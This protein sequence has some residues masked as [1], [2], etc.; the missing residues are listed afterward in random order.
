ML[1]SW[2]ITLIDSLRFQINALFNVS[3]LY[4]LFNVSKREGVRWVKEGV[5][6]LKG[7]VLPRVIVRRMLT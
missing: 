2:M 1:R 6:V 4:R 3:C 7:V 5:D